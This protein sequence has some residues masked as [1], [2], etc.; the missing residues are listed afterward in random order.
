MKRSILLVKSLMLCSLLFV[1]CNDDN[2]I[3]CPEAITGELTDMEVDF[4]GKWTLKSI[5]SEDEVDFTDDDIDNPSTDLFAQYSDCEKDIEYNFSDNRD[6]SFLGGMATADCDN[7]QDIEGTWALNEN[8]ELIIVYGCTTQLTQLEINDEITTFS[9]EG[10]FQYMDVNG[11][12]INTTTTFTY[13][14]E[15]Q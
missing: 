4:T 7:T 15:L 11:D 12:L 1:S 14:K 9:T 13:E 6:Y 5:V 3:K 10:N 8:A 2:D